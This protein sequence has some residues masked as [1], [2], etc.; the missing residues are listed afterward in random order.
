V[1]ITLINHASFL[2]ESKATSIWTDPWTR[3]KIVNNCAALYSPS[4]PVPFERV[5]HIWLSHEH[6]DHFHFPSLKAIPE[7]HRRRITFLHQ[8]HS[9]PRVIEAVWKLGFETIRELPQFRWVTLKPGFDIL[10][11]CVGSMDSF[12]AV[13]TEGECILNM[14]DCVC[15]DAQIRY[16]HRIVGKLS[17]LLTQFSIAQWIGNQADETDAVQQKIRELQYR[18]LTFQPEVTVPFASFA[19]ACNQENEWLNRFMITPAR[20]ME[21]NLPGVNFLYP[22]DVWDSS[23]RKFQTAT[24]VARYMKDIETLQV[25]PTP[26]PV[27]QQTIH[28]AAEKLLQ[29]L[30]K[31]FKK[32]VLSRIEPFEIYT[33]DTNVIL[34]IDPGEGDCEV[35]TATPETAAR[36]R[37]VMCSQVAWYTFAHTWGWNVL[38]GN[39]TFLDRQFKEKGNDDLWERCVNELSTDVL[40][41]DS[42]SRFFRTLGFLWGKKFE[43]LYRFLGK[44]ITDEAVSQLARG[45]APRIQ[46]GSAASV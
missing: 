37:Y 43:I 23:E 1:K 33:H 36:A 10:C 5:E 30:H 25:D 9:S 32:M 17:M 29:S 42:P 31:R 24:A 7:A 2:L 14:N 19:Y 45:S 28:E 4:A 41:F 6:S 11:G 27:D 44:P 35:R 16:I 40:R 20:V 12:L 38:Q 18:V 34:S 13:R 15:T 39:A 26:A 21:L 8:K 46:A 3:G 22:G